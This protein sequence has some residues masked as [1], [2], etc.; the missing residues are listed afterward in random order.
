[1]FFLRRNFDEGYLPYIR[2]YDKDPKMLTS[3]DWILT[4]LAGNGLYEKFLLGQFETLGNR[5]RVT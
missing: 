2:A 1:M 3:C 4:L 5:S